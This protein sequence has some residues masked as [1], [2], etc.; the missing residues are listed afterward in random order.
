LVFH[1]QD[2]YWA[3]SL[4]AKVA[5]LSMRFPEFD[6]WLLNPMRRPLVMG[7]LN[8][9]P[10]SFSDGGQFPDVQSAV[11][12]ARDMVDAGADLLDLGAES[13]RPGALPVPAEEQSRRLLPVLHA[14]RGLDLP[15]VISIDTTQSAVAAAAMADGPV[16]IN[17]VSA[18]ADDPAMA[19]V[20]ARH[21]APVVL[22]HRQGTSATMQQ[23]PVYADVVAEVG[24]FLARRREAAISA[25]IAPHRII[26]DPGIGFGKTLDHNL[27]LLRD[28]KRLAGLAGAPLLLG[29]SRKT[30]IGHITREPDPARRQFGTAATVAWSIANGAAI[31]RVHD[32]S[33]MRQVVEMTQAILFAPPT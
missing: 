30:F 14:I 33:Q 13:T 12:H 7:V 28:L 6:A 29:T 4:T 16:L 18:F 8:L 2:V 27:Q 22:M 21:D 31:V 15:A 10:D 32:V 24:L 9:T 1:L 3:L 23:R 17:D 11:A 20:A 19:P 25:G 26:A 5:E